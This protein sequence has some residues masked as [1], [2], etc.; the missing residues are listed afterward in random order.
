MIPTDR[1]QKKE[2]VNPQS[3]SQVTYFE[4]V[5]VERQLLR[6]DL[7]VETE[8]QQDPLLRVLHG[9]RRLKT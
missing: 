1:K 9:E 5:G 2:V 4:K 7:V 6:I 3:S 8:Y